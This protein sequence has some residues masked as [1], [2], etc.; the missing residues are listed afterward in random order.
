[1]WPF[2]FFSLFLSLS[3]LTFSPPVYLILCFFVFSC[4]S[5]SMT[6]WAFALY[7][8]IWQRVKTKCMKV[9]NFSKHYSI[10]PLKVKILL[11]KTVVLLKKICWK[12]ATLALRSRRWH[13]CRLCRSIG[14]RRGTAVWDR[15]NASL[16]F[17]KFWRAH[18][19]WGRLSFTLAV[20]KCVS[21]HWFLSVQSMPL[22]IGLLVG[23]EWKR[24]KNNQCGRRV[25]QVVNLVFL[26][27][28]AEWWLCWAFTCVTAVS[29]TCTYSH[30]RM[31]RTVVK[32]CTRANFS[33]L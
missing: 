21:I 18:S 12:R 20:M 16:F 30:S 28:R 19:P 1:M 24:V 32:V 23:M 7:W 2:T 14:H 9:R 15:K 26:R 31:H 25:C 33:S 17:I 27:G 13:R 11:V 6:L 3:C 10:N 8:Q 22:D 29:L 4:Q 5:H